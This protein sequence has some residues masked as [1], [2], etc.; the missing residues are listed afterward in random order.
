MIMEALLKAET[1]AGRMLTRSEI[2]KVVA[3]SMRDYKIP[4]NFTPGT[5][6]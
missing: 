4:M 1:K 6:R 3:G 2:L 5:R